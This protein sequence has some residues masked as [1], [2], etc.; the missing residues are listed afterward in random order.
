M[1][2][3]I[4]CNWLIRTEEEIEL[5]P[6]DFTSYTI[7][8]I[9]DE[10]KDYINSKISYPDINDDIL[11]NEELLGIEYW[12]TTYGEFMREWKRLKN[13]PEEL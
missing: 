8:E 10:I 7:D 5:N 2:F 9:E 12:D 3:R 1:K 13:L 6:K 11:S 4:D